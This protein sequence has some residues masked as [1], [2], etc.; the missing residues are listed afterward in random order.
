MCIFEFALNEFRGCDVHEILIVPVSRKI[1]EHF[2]IVLIF[3]HVNRPVLDYLL[4]NLS[5]QR[6]V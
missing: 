4:I 1:R 5:L 6:W 2:Y 3:L